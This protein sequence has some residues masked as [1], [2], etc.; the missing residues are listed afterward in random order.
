M[1]FQIV[2]PHAG[3]GRYTSKRNAERMIARGF[4]VPAGPNA[5]RLLEEE[6]VRVARQLRADMHRNE[7]Y[8]REIA[9][10]R[11]GE[12]V[13]FIWRG[14]KVP[15]Y[16]GA[17]PRLGYSVMGAQVIATPSSRQAAKEVN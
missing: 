8:W 4:A 13:T 17:E 1:I 7:R 12:D 15:A 6:E 14:G 10:E 11:G 16:P 9:V 5:I 2:N 3:G